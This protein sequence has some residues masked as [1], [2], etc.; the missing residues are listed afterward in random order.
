MKP[1]CSLERC[2]VTSSGR[3][4]DGVPP[5]SNSDFRVCC[6]LHSRGRR[7]PKYRVFDYHTHRP[8][9]EGFSSLAFSD[10]DL[11]VSTTRPICQSQHHQQSL[12][13]SAPG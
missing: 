12:Y 10:P 1:L 6:K 2:A 11:P 9:H 3:L 13:E 4:G 5:L 7:E 8:D